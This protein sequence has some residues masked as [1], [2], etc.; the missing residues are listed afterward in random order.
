MIVGREKRKSSS[1]IDFL[2][3]YKE[4][5]KEDRKT[6]YCNQKILKNVK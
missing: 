1:M 2:T 4:E 3:E 6:K 5:Q